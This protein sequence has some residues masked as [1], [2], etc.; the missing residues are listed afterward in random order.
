M[1]K[2]SEKI[3]KA[4]IEGNLTQ[5]QLA[6]LLNISR[7]TVSKWELGVS[8]PETGKLKRL[9]EVLE[10]SIDYLLSDDESKIAVKLPIKQG[11][12]GFEPD[13]TALYSVL[14][15]YEEKADWGFYHKKLREIFN[16]VEKKYGYNKEDAML[17][18]KDMLAKAYFSQ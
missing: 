18:V 6:E 13:W 5:D 11:E 16:E 10:I 9:S 4:R 12:G 1:M 3:A 2:T 14:G 7:Q 15:S 8:L 17:V